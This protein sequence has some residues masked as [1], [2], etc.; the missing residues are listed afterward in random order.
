[1][2]EIKAYLTN[3]KDLALMMWSNEMQKEECN[4][5]MVKH[6]LE[7]VTVIDSMIKEINK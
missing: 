6:W 7:R 4:L 5:A 3:Q 1:M 2:K